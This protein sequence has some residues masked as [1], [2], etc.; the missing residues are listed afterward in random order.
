[1]VM[2]ITRPVIET[3]VPAEKAHTHDKLY[4]ILLAPHNSL[5]HITLMKHWP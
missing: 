5:T 1:M 4:Q 2:G 3:N